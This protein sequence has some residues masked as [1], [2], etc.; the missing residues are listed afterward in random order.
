[1]NY[2]QV[3]WLLRTMG[4][5]TIW[6]NL[7][8]SAA[9]RALGVP[10]LAARSANHVS[11]PKLEYRN[12]LNA[13]DKNGC[14]HCAFC[15]KMVVS[16]LACTRWQVV[17]VLIHRTAQEFALTTILLECFEQEYL[18]D[19][20]V[21]PIPAR[22]AQGRAAVAIVAEAVGFRQ[23][24]PLCGNVGVQGLDLLVD[25]QSLGCNWVETRT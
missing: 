21:Q 8:Q 25:S 10:I 9:S 3:V 5:E 1:M 4:L 2:K 23:V 11:E 24:P 14:A 13:N 15:S 22:P 19:V 20:V 6:P 16:R 18:M 7:G 17:R 12:S